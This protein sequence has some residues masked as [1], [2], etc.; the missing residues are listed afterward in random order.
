MRL[1]LAGFHIESVS[2]LPQFST[3][4]DFEQRTFRSETI[5]SELT[6][7][8][9][10]IGGMLDVCREEGMEAQPLVYAFLGA[11]GPAEDRAVE[12]YADEIAAG[13]SKHKDIDGVLLHLHGA[14]W[15]PSY[16]DPERYI[17][18]KVR[19]AVGPDIP[20]IVAFDYHGNIDTGTIEQATAA[21]AYQKSPHTDMGETGRRAAACM[22]AIL[23]GELEPHMSV[24]R[25]NVMVPSI[26]SA[27]TLSPLTEIL[28]EARRLETEAD[29]FLDISVMAGFS[30]S[31]A[32]NTGFCVI[33][34]SGKGKEDAEKHAARLSDRIWRERHALYRPN[35]IW[36]VEEGVKRAVSLSRKTD[37]PI[38]LLEHAD[39]MNDSTYILS[40]LIAKDVANAAVPFLY[41]ILAAEMAAQAGVGNKAVISIGGHSSDKSGPRLEVAC[42]ILQVEE[43]SYHISG[44]VMTGSK[45]DLGLS[46]LL[47]IGG[48]YVSVVS[49]PA[50]AI[51]KDPFIVFELDPFD[52]D[53]IV[54]RSKTHFRKVYEEIAEEI[55]IID[56]P[57]YGR[58]DLK[59]LNYTNLDISN[60]FPFVP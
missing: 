36:T 7:T 43:K 60:V 37:K 22:V 54:L 18:E 35:E 30:Y 4:E 33:A 16:H 15:A 34:V 17:L 57:D 40:E 1:A 47:K 48:I 11:L 23:K 55:L 45:V 19:T 29:Y 58:A 28:A 10:V 13:L 6:D 21:F 32:P 2:F 59:S 3:Y 31:D 9:T 20:V 56:T 27:T 14:S 39:R 50:F 12:E 8:N 49:F 26:F 41:D 44:P 5:V 51:D 42:E 46:A 24:A 53:I 52:F 38:V 25:P